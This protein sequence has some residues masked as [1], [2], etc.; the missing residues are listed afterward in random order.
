[1][2]DIKFIKKQTIIREK[3]QT[4]TVHARVLRSDKFLTFIKKHSYVLPNGKS[5]VDMSD[6]EEVIK[7]IESKVTS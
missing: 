7:K 2:K 1:M 6:I 4:Q 3:G 5:V